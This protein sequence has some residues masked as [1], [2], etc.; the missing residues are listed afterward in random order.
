MLFSKIERLI[1]SHKVKAVWALGAGGAAEGITK[2]AFGN[3]IGFR[4]SPSIDRNMLFDQCYGG[5]LV[6]TS[7]WVGGK[8]IGTTTEASRRSR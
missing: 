7:S 2:M 5:F 4:A 1:S 8:V 3:R 6:E